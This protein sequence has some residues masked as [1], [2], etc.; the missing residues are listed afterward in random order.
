MQTAVAIGLRVSYIVLAGDKGN[1]VLLDESICDGIDVIYICAYD[2]HACHIAEVILNI[3]RCHRKPFLLELFSDTGG[4]FQARAD[5]F[6][7]IAAVTH[8]ELGIQHIELCLD[9]FYGAGVHHHKLFIFHHSAY[10]LLCLAIYI[11]HL[12]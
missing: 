11:L 4:A 2:P 8:V 5:K 7:G 9:F 1:V 6:D 10:Y 12:I 3:L